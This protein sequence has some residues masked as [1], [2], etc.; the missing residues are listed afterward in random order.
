VTI[1]AFGLVLDLLGVLMLGF[2]LLRLQ[3]K[4]RRQARADHRLYLEL[5]HDYEE[6]ERSAVRLR[7]LSAYAERDGRLDR[8]SDEEIAFNVKNLASRVPEITGALAA[9][10]DRAERL[11]AHLIE[12]N[13]AAH[14]NARGTLRLTA[15]GLILIT[16]GFALQIVGALRF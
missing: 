6:V 12:R 16:V 1:A 14:E 8:A 11:T 9:L 2:D 13:R 15:L 7:G 10:G 3:A 4:L 5:S